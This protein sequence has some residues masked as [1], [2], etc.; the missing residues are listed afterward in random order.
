MR[1][2]A[3]F[4]RLA[5]FPA[6]TLGHKRSKVGM[7]AYLGQPGIEPHLVIVHTVP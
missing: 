1:H 6:R 4:P 3:D 7:N 5:T 2:G